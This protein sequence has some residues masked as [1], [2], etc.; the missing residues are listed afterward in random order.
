[1]H[2][3]KLLFRNAFRHRL[4][5]SLTIL[6]ITIAILS[7][8]MLRT[9]I[10]AWYAGVD[11][12]SAS[13]LVTRNAISL[14]FSLPLSYKERIRQVDGVQ[15]VSYGSW[16]GGLYIDEKNFFPNFAVET[17]QYLKLYPEYVLSP[18]QLAATIRD[19]K[20]CVA[21]RKLAERF[22]WKIGDSIVL[23]GTI[24]PGEWEFVL[25][26][27]YRGREKT[28]DETQ[29][30]FNWDYLNETMKKTVPRRANQ[31]GF[32]MVGVTSPSRAADVALA[33]DR[34]FRNSLAETL[35]ETE[36]AFQ[37]GFISMTEAI[38]IAIQ[39][40]SFVVIVIIM[41]VVANTMA[42][43]ARERIAEYAVFKTLGF[44]GYHIAGLILGESLLIT[45]TGCILGIA[46][47]FPAASAFG[48][49]LS[50]YFPIFN[51][52]PSTIW[53]DLLAAL[54][55]ALVAA[56]FPAWRATTIPIADGLRRIG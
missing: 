32:Y 6:G 28:V 1:M 4:R 39:L 48:S 25:R 16:F 3:A 35:T 56:I 33:I 47:T 22:R 20:G 14:V 38:V 23:K 40:V 15:Q 9:V 24:Y 19:R 5:T 55:V 51:V 43:T 42:M 27:I 36:K 41:A 21:G 29:L 30:F 44:R 8:G 18:E 2:L 37:L 10:S 45:M 7:F 17:E 52:A 26:G 49:A 53:L 13:R 31:V 12:S 11:A 54:L 46:L 34:L 50:A